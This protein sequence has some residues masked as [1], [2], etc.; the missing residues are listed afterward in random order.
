VARPT[1]EQISLA[2]QRLDD[3]GYPDSAS[4]V[5]AVIEPGGWNLLSAASQ[6]S[7]NLAI[8]MDEKLKLDLRAAALKMKVS[9][10]LV[11]EEG[12]QALLD[13]EWELVEPTYRFNKTRDV[14]TVRTVLNV[15]I[16]DDVRQQVRELIPSL[17]E[18]LGWKVTE[19]AIATQWM[20]DELGLAR[21]G[22]NT[23]ALM[24]QIPE[25]VHQHWT[26][27]A[28]E[29][30]LSFQSIVEDGFRAVLDGVWD[31]NRVASM[32]GLPKRK[33]TVRV[34]EDLLG[35]LN[36]A[37]PGVEQRLG[38]RVSPTILAASIVKDR[39]GMPADE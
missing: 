13:G 35:Q 10:S 21:P 7:S 2:A 27:R 28:D 39:L 18:R 19:A 30:D 15:R 20:M 11:V 34:D 31:V 37:L 29:Y 3:A 5:R 9:L 8:T 23:V 17:R 36:A 14:K 24:L 33:L 6:Q 16:K 38:R 22:D 1:R 12:Y 4:V 32:G 25:P 26:E